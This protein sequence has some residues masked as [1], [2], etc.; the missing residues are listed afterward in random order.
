MPHAAHRRPGAAQCFS[1]SAGSSHALG[2]DNAAAMAYALL[3]GA[4]GRAACEKF[5]FCAH[6]H[7]S[8]A[9]ISQRIPDVFHSP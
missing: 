8:R 5:M 1:A 3:V 6:G 4:A 7:E 2:P 9:T